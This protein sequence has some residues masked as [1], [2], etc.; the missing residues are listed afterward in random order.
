L[1]KQRKLVGVLDW[2]NV[3]SM[4]DTVIK[5]ISVML[6]YSCRDKRH[7]HKLDLKLAEFFLKEYRKHHPLSDEEVRFIPDII[8][9]GSVEDFSYAYWMLI[10]DP[11]RAKLYRL[12]LYSKTAQWYNKNREEIS[13]QLVSR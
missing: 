5:D 12:K 4:N 8:A 3:G 11:E 1:W 2:E 13:K 7:K 6:Q 9:A 10:N